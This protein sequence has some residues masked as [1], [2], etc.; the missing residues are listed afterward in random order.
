MSDPTSSFN[1]ETKSIKKIIK[2]NSDNILSICILNDGR[3]ATS[4]FCE[5]IIYN[6]ETD[7]KDME[8][9]ENI[10]EVSHLFLMRNGYLFSSA[11]EEC[12][13]Y[14]IKENSYEIIQKFGNLAGDTSKSIE[15]DNGDIVC[16]HK[17]FYVFKFN[18]AESNYFLLKY[19]EDGKFFNDVIQINSEKIVTSNNAGQQL[20]IWNVKDWSVLNQINNVQVGPYNNCLYLIDSKN[21]VV[22]GT[23]S[24]YLIDLINCNVK[25]KID[26]KYTVFSICPISDKI[27]LT[28]GNEG[29][30]TQ[31]K[32]DSDEINKEQE[33]ENFAK[34]ECLCMAYLSNGVVL[35]ADSK[36]LIVIE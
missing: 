26:N 36:N 1:I 12:I 24:I 25:N 17:G 9:H 29:T 5:I 34:E 11:C 16:L 21:M 31:W 3:I 14:D 30:I 7:K 6:L 2:T 10:E 35:L 13:I 8:I 15:L 19:V 23:K 27:F 33:K 28:T 4:T 20:K 18:P 32:F 22:G